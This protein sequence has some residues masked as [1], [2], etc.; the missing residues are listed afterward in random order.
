[1]SWL[2]I[3]S[4]I[5]TG[6]AKIWDF[7]TQRKQ[8]EYDKQVQQKTWD[9]EDNAI[10]RR[11]DDLTKAGLSPVLAAGTGAQASAPIRAQVPG[12]GL[13][14]TAVEAMQ[15]K[16]ALMRQKQDIATSAAQ[17]KLNQTQAENAEL[18]NLPMKQF[19][20]SNMRINPE[21]H[22]GAEFSPSQFLGFQYAKEALK[23]YEIANS[24][25]SKAK[26]DA[27]KAFED[28]KLSR[29]AAQQA[30]HDFDLTKQYKVR[31]YDQGINGALEAV[32]KDLGGGGTPYAS[33]ISGVLE[34]VLRSA[35]KNIIRR[36]VGN[37][38][39]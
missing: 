34:K 35:P 1:M 26:Y 31:S 29:I 23:S 10:Q 30:Q 9:R 3:G 19:L 16:T 14:N 11:V 33:A 4:A 39:R 21:S 38:V 37:Y 32:V 18:Q 28:A 22:E 27:E 8:F 36:G 7:F 13:G 24:I 5:A 15:L 6:A 25:Q 12:A 20:R 2:G 17:E